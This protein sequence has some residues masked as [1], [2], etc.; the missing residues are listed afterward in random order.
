LTLIPT[1]Y[2]WLTDSVHRVAQHRDPDAAAE[3]ASARDAHETIQPL[4]A[5]IARIQ[6]LKR[7]AEKSTPPSPSFDWRRRSSNGQLHRKYQQRARAMPIPQ[8][9]PE[10]LQIQEKM[11]AAEARYAPI[12]K[13][14]Q[15]LLHQ[16]FGDGRLQSYFQRS[17]DGELDAIPAPR[18]WTKAGY[19]AFTNGL[20]LSRPE[21][22]RAS[23]YVLVRETDLEA[24]LASQGSPRNVV[25]P[26]D[27]ASAE[28]AQPTEIRQPP[29]QR[30]PYS[31]EALSAWFVLRVRIW[32]KGVPFPTEADDRKAAGLEFE[33]KISRD[34]FRDIRRAKTPKDWRKSGPRGP[35]K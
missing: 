27:H 15:T 2:L 5:E 29:A 20:W 7:R 10:Q 16:S 12:Y 13:A 28:A 8:L 35:R 24:L 14:A 21:P 32:A 22:S 1:G 4:L 25:P 31:P 11:R 26:P 23:G 30:P 3:L 9:T 19:D 17:S 6:D 34:E 33:G 18:W